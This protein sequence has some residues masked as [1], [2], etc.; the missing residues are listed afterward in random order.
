M[1]CLY[2]SW[3]QGYRDMDRTLRTQI[4]V[5]CLDLSS[6]VFVSLAYLWSSVLPKIINFA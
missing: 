5:W 1:P 4:S 6:K 3:G 2:A